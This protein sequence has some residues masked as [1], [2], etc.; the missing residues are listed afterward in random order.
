MPPSTRGAPISGDCRQ[1]RTADFANTIEALELADA[2]L[3][4]V[5]G[6]FFNLAG[7]DSNPAREAL[8]RDFAPKFSA[9]S[10]EI[11]NNFSLFARVAELWERNASPRLSD[12]EQMRVLYLTHRSFR[13][14]GRGAGGGSARQA[15][16]G[17]GP[18]GRAGHV[19]HAEPAGR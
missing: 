8:Q 10:S 12:S 16:R 7:S 19:V 2:T 3:D 9:Y 14:V 15:D 11:T 5:A 4:R 17:E 13:A 18:S 1:P 6:V